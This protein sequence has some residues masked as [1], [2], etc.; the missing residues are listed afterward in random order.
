[1]LEGMLVSLNLGFEHY[2]EI[3]FTARKKVLSFRF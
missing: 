1:M 2:W 3:R